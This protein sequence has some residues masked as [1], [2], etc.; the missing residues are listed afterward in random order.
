MVS[1]HRHGEYRESVKSQAYIHGIN[2]HCDLSSVYLFTRVY[3]I[4][5]YTLGRLIRVKQTL[6]YSIQTRRQGNHAP[7]RLF[8]MAFRES[9][10]VG[11]KPARRRFLE[12]ILYGKII[13]EESQ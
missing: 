8:V 4:L 5:F 3:S 10:R 2:R 13:L 1:H 12:V 6:K 11:R 7:A 9:R